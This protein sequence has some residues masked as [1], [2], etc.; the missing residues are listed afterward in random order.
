MLASTTIKLDG[1][2]SSVHDF[3]SDLLILQIAHLKSCYILIGSESD[4]LK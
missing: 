2:L 1:H 4:F 3:L